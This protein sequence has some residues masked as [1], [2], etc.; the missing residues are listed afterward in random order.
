MINDVFSPED[1]RKIAKYPHLIGWMVGK[2]K[3]TKMHS[4]WIRDLWLPERHTCLQAH[5]GAYKTTAC[6]EI[7]II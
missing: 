7:G 5:R 3:L 1:L 4:K 2:D 6:T